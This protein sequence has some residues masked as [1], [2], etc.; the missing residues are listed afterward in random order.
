MAAAQLAGEDFLVGLD[1]VR[2]DQ[3]GQQVTPVPGLL[4]RPRPGSRAGSLESTAR[5][6]AGWPRRPPG[7]G[8]AARRA[9][10]ELPKAVTIDIDATDVEVYGSKKRACLHLP[11]QRPPCSRAAWPRPRSRCRHLLPATRPPLVRRALLAALAALPRRSGRAARPDR[12][13]RHAATSPDLPAPPPRDMPS[14]SRQASPACEAL[15]D[16][17]DACGCDTDA[18]AQSRLALPSRTGHAPC[19]CP[20]SSY[21]DQSPPPPSRA[22]APC[23]HQRAAD[24]N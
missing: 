5:A 24:P 11:G 22:A 21:P 15:P 1:R 3:A 23:T 19:C 14:P 16:T 2:A 10:A 13:A 18:G 17:R 4:P 9:R 20:P 6:E 12:A 8:P 7:Y